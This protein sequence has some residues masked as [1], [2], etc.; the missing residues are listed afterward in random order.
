MARKSAAS[1]KSKQRPQRMAASSPDAAAVAARI[2][3]QMKSEVVTM[4]SDDKYK[5]ERVPT[6]ILAIDRL[7]LGGLARGRHHEIYGDWTA[8]KSLILYEL[9]VRAQQRGEVCA[10]VDAEDVFNEEW[11][12]RLGGNPD[13]LIGF[14]PQNANELGNVLQLFVQSSPEVQAVDV[15]GIDSVASLMTMEEEAHDFQEGDARVASLARLMSLLLR[16][17]TTQNDNTTFIWTN[18][19]RD[20]IAR[21]PGLQSTPGGRSLG[22]YASTRIEMMRNAK[23]TEPQQ[24]VHQGKWVE[25]KVATGQWVTC[26][27]KKEK[28][29]GRPEST[30]SLMLNYDYNRFDTAR[31]II[32]IGMEDRLIER[33]GDHFILPLPGGGTKKH[34]GIKRTVA[35]IDGDPD[36]FD[37]LRACI[38]EQTAILAE[39]ATDG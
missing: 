13:D 35:A 16:K 33:S 39:G 25:R 32:D 3:A 17:V 34:H 6:G 23:E 12:I 36:L 26:T 19:W 20:K 30:K 18:Q 10:I 2:N 9:L 24:Q 37:F 8:G 7:T 38:E 22:F 21:I 15:V 28:T 1:L 29:G 31:Q 11:F 5:L 14:Q 27:L 4:A